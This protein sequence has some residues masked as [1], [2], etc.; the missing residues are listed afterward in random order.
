MPSQSP[1]QALMLLH[2]ACSARSPLCGDFAREMNIFGSALCDDKE[3]VDKTT[4]G[5]QIHAWRARH[6]KVT[7]QIIA[8]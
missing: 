6:G 4:K 3:L 8:S 2:A 5:T 1:T 7:A